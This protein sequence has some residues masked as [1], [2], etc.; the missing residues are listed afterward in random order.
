[1]NKRRRFTPQRMRA[2]RLEL[3]LTQAEIAK[4]LRVA[5]RTVRAYEAGTR[6]PSGPVTAMYEALRDGT[7]RPTT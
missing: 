7:I 3:D 2:I 5:E 4:A 6:R 1:M